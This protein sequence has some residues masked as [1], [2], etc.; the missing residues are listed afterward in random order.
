MVF[1]KN[2]A[3][4]K[5]MFNEEKQPRSR[6]SDKI[7]YSRNVSDDFYEKDDTGK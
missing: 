3:N 5:M 1:G 4:M 2:E 7:R 6:Y